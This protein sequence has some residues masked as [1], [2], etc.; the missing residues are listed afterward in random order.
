MARHRTARRLTCRPLQE[1]T[2]AVP[3][4]PQEPPHAH[5][6]GCVVHRRRDGQPGRPAA[7]IAARPRTP[8]ARPARSPIFL[9]F[10]GLVFSR[11]LRKHAGRIGAATERGLP[12]YESF[13]ASSWVVM[14]V[15]MGGGMAL[16]M[17]APGARVGDRLLLQRPR[18]G[19]VPVRAAVRR[20]VRAEGRPRR[21]SALATGRVL[22]AAAGARAGRPRT[23]GTS[24]NI[25]RP[26]HRSEPRPAGSSSSMEPRVAESRP[27]S[28]RCKPRAASA[29]ADGDRSLRLRAP[30]GW[31]AS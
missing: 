14:A 27:S 19:P 21:R 5:R 7:R 23:T 1:A 16:R 10:Y 24:R 2:H 13:N 17:S 8:R 12:F 20:R 29:V 25:I 31:P 26:T 11:L 15:M 18:G 6:G 22:T 30:A 28:V 4:R 3:E 9:A